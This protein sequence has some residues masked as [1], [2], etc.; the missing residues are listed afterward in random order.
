MEWPTSMWVSERVLCGGCVNL[1]SNN[2]IYHA[3]V[4]STKLH[5]WFES[6]MVL[7]RDYGKSRNIPLG[8]VGHVRGLLITCYYFHVVINLIAMLME[9]I[10][11]LNHPVSQRIRAT[12]YT[13]HCESMAICKQVSFIVEL[14]CTS[15]RNSSKLPC[16]GY[17]QRGYVNEEEAP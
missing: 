5:Y 14:D 12:S 7:G 13:S 10:D 16:P 15:G 3:G 6:Y 4:A 17:R 8:L 11:I 2:I 1:C 9:L